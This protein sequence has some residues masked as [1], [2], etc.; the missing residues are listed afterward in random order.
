MKQEPAQ[1]GSCTATG[2]TPEVKVFVKGETP[3]AARVWAL[4]SRDTAARRCATMRESSLLLMVLY[5]SAPDPDGHK[6]SQHC[7]HGCPAQHKIM[8]QVHG[9]SAA[10]HLVTAS[11]S[12]IIG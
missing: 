8:Q 10:Q 9:P 11:R 7:L 1:E 12:L 6:S 3:D 4:L 5:S 2:D